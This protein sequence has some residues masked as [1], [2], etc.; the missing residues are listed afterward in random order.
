MYVNKYRLYPK[1]LINYKPKISPFSKMIFPIL[2][3]LAK[4]CRT[5]QK[6]GGI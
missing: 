2:H 3:I 6:K 5:S 4:Y 1:L